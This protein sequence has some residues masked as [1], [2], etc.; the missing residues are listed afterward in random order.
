MLRCSSLIAMLLAL[1]LPWS[2]F[3]LA[4]EL[5]VEEKETPLVLA[6]E[7][8]FVQ[9]C[10]A[11]ELV[12]MPLGLAVEFATMPRRAVFNQ[13]QSSGGGGSYSGHECL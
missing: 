5:A 9:L 10:L 13:R 3:A 12:A 8:G 2:S 6:V 4:V 1:G 11:V 7:P